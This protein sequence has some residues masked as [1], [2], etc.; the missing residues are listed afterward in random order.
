MMTPA[1][2]GP[3]SGAKAAE[4]PLL[5]LLPSVLP[6]PLPLQ[7]LLLLVL[8]LRVKLSRSLCI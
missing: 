4:L 5:P 3:H 2:Y 1:T 7:L 8:L 6:L